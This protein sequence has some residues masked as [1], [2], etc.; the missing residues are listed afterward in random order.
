VYEHDADP[1]S[2]ETPKPALYCE[3][4]ERVKLL[5]EDN[6]KL[7]SELAE[8]R[9]KNKKFVNDSLMLYRNIESLLVE[10]DGN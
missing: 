7:R 1:K 5:T 8:A 10:N 9:R 2:S 3:L 4:E 6:R